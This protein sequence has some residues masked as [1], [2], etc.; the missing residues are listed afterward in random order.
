MSYFIAFDTSH[1]PR[2][3][4]NDNYTQL[5]DLLTSNNFICHEFFEPLITQDSL[6]SYDILVLACPDFSQISLQEILEIK[7]WIKNDGGSLLLLSH[8]GGD[9]GRKSNLSQ[10]SEQ[11]GI[12]FE[13]DQVLDKKK[14]NGWEN[15]PI[16]SN[17]INNHPI[18][19]KIENICYRAGCSLTKIGETSSIILSNKTS[20]PLEVPLVCVSILEKGKIVCCGSYELFRDNIKGGIP[21]PSHHILAINIFNWLISDYRIK[22]R[23]KSSFI[24][25]KKVVENDVVNKEQIEQEKISEIS[26]SPEDLI[27]EFNGLNDKLR[28]E[29]NILNFVEKK[30][31]SGNLQNG[32]YQNLKYNIQNR[33][34]NIKKRIKEIK[35]ILDNI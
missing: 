27:A 20:E 15:L 25:P 6:Q 18:L 8:A 9:K 4:I 33:I 10:L 19:N 5:N 31:K 28:S 24:A 7:N 12:I 14:N 29:I 11:F 21:F 32:K 23:S 35:L 17:F 34:N 30:F 26:R 1:N 22:L 13:N 2:G 16:I 3:R